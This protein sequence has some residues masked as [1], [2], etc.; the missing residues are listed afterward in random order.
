MK[1]I[2]DTYEQPYW[3]PAQKRFRLGNFSDIKITSQTSIM[4]ASRVPEIYILF[5]LNIAALVQQYLF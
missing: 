5:D 2:Q 1:I 3:T 4:T